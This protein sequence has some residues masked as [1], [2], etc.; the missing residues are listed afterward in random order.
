MNRQAGIEERKRYLVGL[1]V[2]FLACGLCGVGGVFK[3]RLAMSSIVMGCCA[4]LVFGLSVRM[5][6]V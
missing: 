1:R 4:A 5:V 6:G 2:F 3:N